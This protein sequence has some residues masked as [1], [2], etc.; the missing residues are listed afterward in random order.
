MTHE[1]IVDLCRSVDC[2]LAGVDFELMVL[3]DLKNPKGRT[4]LQIWY[5]S[6]R[7]KTGKVGTRKGRKWYLSSH[8]IDDE[9]IKTCFAAFEAAVKHE[10]LEGF[11]VANVIIFNPHLNYKELIKISHREVSRPPKPPSYTA[12]DFEF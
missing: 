5:D 10:I 12:N 1:E 4:F 11:R 2:S 7:S 9:I 6:P 8:M 3:K